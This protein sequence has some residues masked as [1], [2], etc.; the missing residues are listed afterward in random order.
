M[1]FC[2]LGLISSIQNAEW[3]VE[4]N[5]CLAT[6]LTC[7]RKI[8]RSRKRKER[9]G[10]G[11]EI[12]SILTWG[13]QRRKRNQAERQALQKGLSTTEE[14]FLFSFKDDA[15]AKEK[16]LLKIIIHTKMHHVP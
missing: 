1:I 15:K 10:L 16:R 6:G 4:W 14:H 12:K 7:I 5:S 13:E 3:W 8:V 9:G 11:G 2:Y